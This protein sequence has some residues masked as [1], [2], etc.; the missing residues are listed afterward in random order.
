[1]GKKNL[2]TFENWG[3][4]PFLKRGPSG[5]PKVMDKYFNGKKGF[6]VEPF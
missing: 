5:S 6:K 3:G 4:D 2:K 1:L